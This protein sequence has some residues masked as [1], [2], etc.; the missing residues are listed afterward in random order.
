VQLGGKLHANNAPG[1]VFA[2]ELLRLSGVAEAG[3][4]G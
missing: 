3:R 2:A 4:Q 1:A